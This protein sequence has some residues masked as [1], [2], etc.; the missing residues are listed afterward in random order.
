MVKRLDKTES[1]YC[2]Y[3]SLAINKKDS[4]YLIYLKYY[5][6]GLWSCLGITMNELHGLM[7]PMDVYEYEKKKQLNNSNFSRI[8]ESDWLR[9]KLGM[10]DQ[11]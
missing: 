6:K 4:P 3:G 5:L 8:L 7:T 9:L 1:T 2:S 10:L 11:I